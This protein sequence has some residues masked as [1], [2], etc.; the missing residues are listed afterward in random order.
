MELKE[1]S[2]DE[3]RYEFE[4]FRVE[5]VK[6]L[7]DDRYK[8]ISSFSKS[9][10]QLLADAMKHV[11]MAD[12]KISEEELLAKGLIEIMADLPKSNLDEKDMKFIKNK[13]LRN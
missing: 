2:E 4:D 10:K 9:K 13:I 6:I 8:I 7:K 11:I 1:T 5:A 12:E 3:D